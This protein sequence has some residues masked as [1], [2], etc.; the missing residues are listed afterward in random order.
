M[1]HRPQP[2]SQRGL[3]APPSQP[4]THMVVKHSHRDLRGNSGSGVCAAIDT[5]SAVAYT[6]A[7]APFQPPAER[8]P[9]SE[10]AERGNAKAWQL[11]HQWGSQENVGH[12][13]RGG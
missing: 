8:L 7:A 11:H 3:E 2:A 13:G 6:G 10:L 4:L 5:A 9:V 1:G 12:Q